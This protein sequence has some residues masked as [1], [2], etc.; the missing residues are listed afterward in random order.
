MRTQLNLSIF[1]FLI[2][3]LF[4]ANGAFAQGVEGVD[5]GSETGVNAATQA[6][7]W[8]FNNANSLRFSNTNNCFDGDKV[9]SLSQ[10]GVGI[11]S[12]YNITDK[13]QAGLMINQS[14]WN[15]SQ[16]NSDDESSSS[17]FGGGVQIGYNFLSNENVVGQV[18]ASGGLASLK[19]TWTFS[20]GS[21]S[22]LTGS[23]NNYEIGV[24]GIVPIGGNNLFGMLALK[25]FGHADCFEQD[26]VEEQYRTSGFGL[27]VEQSSFFSCASFDPC[28]KKGGE[29]YGD[30]FGLAGTI[31]LPGSSGLWFR[32]G[33]DTYEYTFLSENLEQVTNFTSINFD[34]DPTYYVFD[35]IGASLNIDLNS[36]T[37]KDDETD[38]KNGF[39]HYSIAPG[40]IIHVPSLPQVY[41]GFNY[42]F[43]SQSST[44][45][46]FMGE[47]ETVSDG[48]S[49]WNAKLGYAQPMLQDQFITFGVNYGSAS[50][51]DSDFS[52]KGWGVEFGLKSI[53]RSF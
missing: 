32:A 34:L 13:L 19:D 42:G 22:E 12:Y 43:G 2:L 35:Y 27:D 18:Y 44:F 40:V 29:A 9:S 48:R 10:I 25:A 26:E 37:D 49:N 39:S 52:D 4:T 23:N 33:Q 21:E 51:N 20:G 45:T 38:A 11:D 17:F 50:I 31:T 28:G 1:S 30:N 14:S 15:S 8:G 5:S 41:G 24:R 16:E 3:F 46:N 36:R 7:N 47:E 6:G 53:I